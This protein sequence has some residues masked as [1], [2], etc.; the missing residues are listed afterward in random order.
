MNKWCYLKLV[1]LKLLPNLLWSVVWYL[2]LDFFI[3]KILFYSI[4]YILGSDEY[5]FKNRW[6]VSIHFIGFLDFVKFSTLWYNIWKGNQDQLIYWFLFDERVF[7][8][9]HSIIL[10]CNMQIASFNTRIHSYSHWMRNN[11]FTEM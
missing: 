10:L 9:F 4:I 11:Y 1:T 3:L 5:V 7:F 2:A 6:M 8:W